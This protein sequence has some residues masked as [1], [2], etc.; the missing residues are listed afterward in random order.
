MQVGIKI[1]VEA[2][3]LGKDVLSEVVRPRMPIPGGELDHFFTLK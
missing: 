3:I 2:R 1:R